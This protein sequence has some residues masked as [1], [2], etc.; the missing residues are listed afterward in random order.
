[1]PKN[2]VDPLLEGTN[3]ALRKYAF[4]NTQLRKSGPFGAVMKATIT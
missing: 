3:S 2:I 4:S 1:L